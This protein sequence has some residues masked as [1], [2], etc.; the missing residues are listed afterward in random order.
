MFK[1]LLRL[2]VIGAIALAATSGTGA[3]FSDTE[4]STGNTFSAGAIDLKIDNESYYNG[5]FNDGTSWELKDLGEGDFFFNFIDLKPD[6]EGEDTISLHVDDNDAWACMNIEITENTDNGCN[7]PEAADGDTTCGDPG[8]GEGELQNEI[9]FVWWADDGDN[10]LETDESEKTFIQ[11]SLA[12]I[13]STSVILA[14]ANGQGILNDGPLAG[15]QTYYIGKAWC[16]GTLTLTPIAQDRKGK[17]GDNGPLDRGTGISC[18]GSVLDNK[19]Q[20]DS[21][22]GNI[23]FTAVQSRHNDEF[24]CTDGGG[25]GCI[26]KADVM[27]VLDR[28]GSVSNNLPTL[29][30]AAKAFV[31]SLSPSADG[32]HIGVVSFANSGTLDLHLSDD[33]VAIDAAIDALVSGGTTNLAE[34][35]DLADDELAD[36]HVHDRDDLDAPDYIIIITDGEPNA[37]GGAAG[38]EAEADA[39]KAEG[40]EIFAVGV[41]INEN[42]ANFLRNDIVSP[43]PATHYFDA[44]DFASLQQILIDLTMCPGDI[45]AP[46][47]Q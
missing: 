16:F 17:T 35:I 11:S 8:V 45:V 9:N 41:G 20:T 36:G 42:N 24:T 29:K 27:L 4:S 19:T 6:D 44:A 33:Q 28:S 46:N 30:T 12:D 40:V 39:A 21:V 2:G 22:M 15:A 1:I 26:D 14:D 3:F 32:V 7:E 37:G 31:S 5:A 10:V 38:A 13:A 43:P 34:G 47:D 18:D 25:L 23:T